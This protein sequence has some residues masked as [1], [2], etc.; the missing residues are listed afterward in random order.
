MT[1]S[2]LPYG[3]WPSPITAS[4]LVSGAV[5]INEVVPDGPRVWWVESRP[6]EGGRSALMCWHDGAATEVTP[7]EADVRT[8]VH[9]YGGGAWWASDGVAF[10]TDDNDQRLRRVVAGAEPELLTPEPERARGLR[11]A[12]GRPSPSG[13][14]YVCVRERHDGTAEAVNEIVA[15]AT[16]GSN[17]V[18]VLAR[19]ADFYASPRLS[20]D[21]TTLAW[22][23][24][25][26]PDMPWDVTELWTAPFDEAT[27]TCAPASKLVGNGDEALQQPEWFRDGS[28]H[29]VTDR[30]E[31]WDL[32]RVDLT[33][34]DL[35]PEVTG[36]FEIVTPHWV[37][38]L[39]RYAEGVHVVA[40]PAGDEL[41][42]GPPT[43]Y[44]TITSLRRSGDVVAFVGSSYRHEAEVARVIDGHLEVLRPARDLGLDPGFLPPPEAI[45]FPTAQ[46]E[47]DGNGHAST[48]H[49][50]FY[51]PANPD[52]SGPP[53]ATPPLVVAIHGGP[54]AA[55]R[56][57]LDLRHRYWTSRGFAVVD[58]DY[59]GSTGYGRTFR[60]SLDGR[61]GVA[62][63]EDAV[64][65][66]R[67]LADRGDVDGDRLVIR[68]G[69]AGGFTALAALAFH[70]AFAAG[71]SHY[72]IADLAALAADTHKF[73]SRYLDRLVGPYPEA[74]DVYRARSPIHHVEGFDAPLIVL[75]GAEDEVVPPNQAEMIV[76][77]L[78]AKQVPVAYLVFAGEQHGFR[79]AENIVA[80]LEAELSFYGQ[81]LGFEPA[82]ELTPVAIDNL[83]R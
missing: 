43:P 23:Q 36:A 39:S 79:R 26:H 2:V 57:Q 60:H 63:V 69:S 61:W 78:R 41:S 42:D 73:E 77:G 37:F 27:G 12:D 75:Q 29:V 50:L 70:D 76:D 34:G 25:Q 15:V 48:A 6:G 4:F 35:H 44:S 13:A 24:W 67:F 20:P 32:H 9:E 22:I 82:D 18:E 17:R 59:R 30:D 49:G 51:R 54:T 46:S 40:G 7:P 31:W 62:D 38:G 55:A 81:V 47:G 28:L 52:V 74:D 72:G 21:G 33:T 1:A 11:Y 3:A 10:Y 66:A 64:A 68:G 53:D 19:G 16:D 58:V 5:G 14:W 45:S 56:R 71:A 80:A 83:A 65:A 8:R